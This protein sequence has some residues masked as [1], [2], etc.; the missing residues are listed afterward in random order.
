VFGTRPEAIKLCPVLL[1]MRERAA[2]FSVK[3]CVTAQHRG[4]LDQ[5]LA[6]FQVTPPSVL[7]Y[8]PTVPT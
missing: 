1:H 8:T 2:E 4:M 5:V 6:A 3:S 7:L